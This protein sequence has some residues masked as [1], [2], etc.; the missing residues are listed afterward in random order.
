MSAP[1]KILPIVLGRKTVT[2]PSSLLV[3]SSF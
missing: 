1:T 3:M 2:A